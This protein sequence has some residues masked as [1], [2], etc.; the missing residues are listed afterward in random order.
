[1]VKNPDFTHLPTV[2]YP[3]AHEGSESE[4]DRG[5]SARNQC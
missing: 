3:L 1:M 2:L 5:L 4:S